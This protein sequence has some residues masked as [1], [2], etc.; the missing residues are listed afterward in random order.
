LKPIYLALNSTIYDV[1][2][3]RNYYGPGASYD[4]FSGRDASR[5]F[6]TGCFNEDLTGDLRGVEKMYIPKSPS[7]NENEEISDEERETA[8][9]K[10][11]E[12]VEHWQKVFSGQT[13]KAYFEV[14]RVVKEKNWE[15]KEPMRK[16]CDRAE[17]KR[18]KR[19]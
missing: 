11:R 9:G 8:L 3:G 7:G 19:S 16:L 12:V 17:G 18:L 2:A 14:G 15:V 4:F 13:G 1:T 6:I 5:A 10:V